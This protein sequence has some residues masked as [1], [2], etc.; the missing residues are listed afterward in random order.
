[1]TNKVEFGS[2]R[3]DEPIRPDSESPADLIRTMHMIE[4][5]RM[6]KTLQEIGD[7]YQISRER[8]RQILQS[9]GF[10]IDISEMRKQ[11][12][13]KKQSE[14]LDKRKE[15][16]VKISSNW[17][18]YKNYSF[19]QLANELVVSEQLLRA[20]ISVIQNIYL[21]ANSESAIPRIWTKEDCLV[22]LKKAATYEFPLTVQKFQKL[23]QTGE[24]SGPTVAIVYA[25]FGSWVQACRSAGVEYGEAQR[26][27]NRKWNDTE[28]IRFVRQFLCAQIDGKWS[29][30]NYEKWRR[31]PD[32]EGPSLPLLRLR[33]G[34]WS[35]IRVM[36][37]EMDEPTL[38]L[39][40]YNEMRS[41]E[42]R[43]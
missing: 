41:G 18:T 11:K 4:L 14:H 29:I 3:H 7:A 33:L 8:V 42:I 23:L 28:L 15:I 19:K 36:A 17:E 6:G 9:M 2:L 35:E 1:M 21:Q 38:D 27:Y 40:K 30:E 22:S 37:I 10:E 12:S 13:L 39:A 43:N 20:S 25:R 32:V 34:T 31:R 24:I 16:F 5:R 26:E